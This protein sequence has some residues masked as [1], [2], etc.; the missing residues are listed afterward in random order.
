MLLWINGS[1]SSIFAFDELKTPLLS[2]NIHE[3]KYLLVKYVD[4]Y[5]ELDK[6]NYKIVTKVFGP[7]QN[8]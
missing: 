2:N 8:T 1:E 5:E 4:K 7:M 6:I 3:I